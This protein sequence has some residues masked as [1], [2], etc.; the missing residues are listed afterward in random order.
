MGTSKSK[1][2]DEYVPAL[3]RLGSGLVRTL[4]CEMVT[5]LASDTTRTLAQFAIR[6][7]VHTRV[8]NVEL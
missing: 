5:H 6:S 8:P 4:R 1:I 3:D 7:V 2:V